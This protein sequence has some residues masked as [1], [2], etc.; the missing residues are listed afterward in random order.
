VSSPGA[1]QRASGAAAAELFASLRDAPPDSA[2]RASIRER[3]VQLHLPLVN[4][5]ARRFA[6]RGVPH[7]DLFQVGSI[8][9][10]KAIDG[11]DPDRGREFTSYA[12][13]TIVGEIKRYFRDSGWLLHVPRR[14]KELQTTLSRLREQLS[15][16]LGH[17]PTPAQLAEA[18]DVPVD[19]VLEA[20]DAAQAY[21]ADTLDGFTDADGP[22]LPAAV[23]GITEAGFEEVETR[24]RL[25]DALAVLPEQE[26]EVL[27]LRFV[28]DR[29]QAEIAQ[30]IGVSQMQVSRLIARAL[31]KLRDRLE[32]EP[33]EG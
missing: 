6:G 21:S 10:L 15:Q 30:L 25:R 12:V 17:A 8:G 20:L 16:E 23:L 14:A 11:F 5:L 29:K 1:R 4:H 13:P 19:T 27:L 9:L 33:G 26:R 32:P 22:N 24:A 3:L 18:A 2:E 28:A 7:D 31:A